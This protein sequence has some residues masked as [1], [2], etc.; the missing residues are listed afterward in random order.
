LCQRDKIITF[1]G[2]PG[3]IFITPSTITR[4][5]GLSV[6]PRRKVIVPSLRSVK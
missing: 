3:P 5:P 1:T 6:N 4:S 2:A